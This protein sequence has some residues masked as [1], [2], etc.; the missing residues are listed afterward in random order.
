MQLR[1]QIAYKHY[2]ESVILQIAGFTIK[3]HESTIH[4][5]VVTTSMLAPTLVT[6][7]SHAY[8]AAQN[9]AHSGGDHVLHSVQGLGLTML[10]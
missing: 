2:F 5:A 1:K 8:V 7:V 10:S 9:K 3:T 4:F 6:D